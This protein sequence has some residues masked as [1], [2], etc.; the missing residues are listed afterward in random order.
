M[1]SD[2]SARC[3]RHRLSSSDPPVPPGVEELPAAP[4]PLSKGLEAAGELWSPL[5]RARNLRP[6][7]RGSGSRGG[8]PGRRSSEPPPRS[9]R[10]SV[11]S[12]RLSPSALHRRRAEGCP[13]EGLGIQ[14]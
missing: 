5:Q 13:R 12:P 9:H 2:P 6:V 14:E 7:H 11:A 1:T 8:A 10:G 4:L 3:S